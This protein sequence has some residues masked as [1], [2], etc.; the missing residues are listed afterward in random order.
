MNLFRLRRKAE[1]TDDPQMYWQA[2]A[3]FRA[4]GMEAAA[5]R[6]AERARHYEEAR[7]EEA[8]AKTVTQ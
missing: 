8:S 2:A 3:E 4:V 5:E 1:E 7:S 6:C